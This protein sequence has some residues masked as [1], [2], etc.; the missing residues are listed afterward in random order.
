MGRY[1]AI[2]SQGAGGYLSS[3]PAVFVPVDDVPRVVYEPKV[4]VV[5]NSEVLVQWEPPRHAS[6]LPVSRYLVEWD[7]NLGFNSVGGMPAGSVY[8]NELQH[9]PVVDEVIIL[10]LL[11]PSPVAR[12][13]W[14]IAA[15][16]C[17]T[18]CLLLHSA[19]YRA[20]LV[21]ILLAAWSGHRFCYG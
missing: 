21:L 20:F 4:E 8:V 5:G 7:L 18:V 11:C 14:V 19:L 16:V 15:F 10:V 3:T 13:L 9:T 2:N 12:L 17:L 1:A 6:G